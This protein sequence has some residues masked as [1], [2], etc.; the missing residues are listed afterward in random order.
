MTLFSERNDRKPLAQYIT[1]GFGFKQSDTAPGNT[2]KNSSTASI[3]TCT[4]D[5]PHVSMI[6]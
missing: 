5:T 4:R 1:R 3:Y 2:D 6:H